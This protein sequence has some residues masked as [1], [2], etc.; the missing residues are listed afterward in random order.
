PSPAE[1]YWADAQDD[2]I[3]RHDRG[4]LVRRALLAADLVGLL[5]ALF[6]SQAFF[7]NRSTLLERLT[8]SSQWLLFVAALPVWIVA[9]K[10]YRLY[11]R[12]EERTDHSTVDDFTG[13][14]HLVTVWVWVAYGLGRATG[15]FKPDLEKS[16]AFW[17]FAI[18]LIPAAR[19]VARS[20]CRR[21]PEYIQ[22]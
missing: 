8:P 1:A 22:N 21:R 4:W 3:A 17:A 10:V 9:A 6:A 12:D 20:V 18:V 5:A 13:V 11:D 16:T 7:T 14:F 2:H 19:G 15:I